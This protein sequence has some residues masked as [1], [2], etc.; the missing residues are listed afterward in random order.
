[1]KT[2]KINCEWCKIEFDVLLSEI[3]RGNG[4]FCSKKC[5]LNFGRETI[6]NKYKEHNCACAQCGKTFY[7][8]VSKRS[9]SRSG[10]YFC[11]RLCK[12]TGQRIGGIKE[13]QP[14][15]YG[16]QLQSYRDKAMR[17]LPHRCN[18]CGYNKIPGIL[19]VHHKDRERTNNL[20]SNLE[21]LC[22]NCHQ[23]EHFLT[24][25]GRFS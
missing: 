2:E 14:D 24:K 23:E 4:K 16:N 18:R 5:S 17:E 11:S 15:H 22:P 7:R 12:D 21:I 13:I 10:L 8:N 3:K 1:M 9:V 19:E 6:K 20:I 25:S